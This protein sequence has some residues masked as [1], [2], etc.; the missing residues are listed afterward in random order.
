VEFKCVYTVLLINVELYWFVTFIIMQLST[1]RW[2]NFKNISWITW[3]EK[4]R[5]IV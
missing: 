4:Y 1:F 3:N 5:A 2:N